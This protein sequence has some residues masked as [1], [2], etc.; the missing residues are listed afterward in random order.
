MCSSY[1]YVWRSVFFREVL[2]MLGALAGGA[3]DIIGGERSN[4]ANEDESEK[5]R[6]FQMIMSSTAHRRE[7]NDLKKAGLNPILSSKYG[8]ASTPSGSTAIHMN[9][10][11]NAGKI[12]SEARLHKKQAANIDADTASKREEAKLKKSQRAVADATASGQ[13]YSNTAK[14]IESE[15]LEEVPVIQWLKMVTGGNPAGTAKGI[16]KR[17]QGGKGLRNKKPKLDKKTGE[18]KNYESRRPSNQRR[19]TA[20][21]KR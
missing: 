18:I 21:S 20:T 19:R 13:R 12:L 15:A 10:A 9:S 8:G 16:L 17:G 1:A 3:L 5:N 4:K 2:I 7:V 6:F 14:R 11:A